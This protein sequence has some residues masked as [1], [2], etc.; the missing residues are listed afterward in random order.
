MMRS[1]GIIKYSLEYT[2]RLRLL[3][4]SLMKKIQNHDTSSHLYKPFYGVVENARAGRKLHNIVYKSFMAVVEFGDLKTVGLFIDLGIDL[5]KSEK[6]SEESSEGNSDESSEESWEEN[7]NLVLQRA[8]KNRCAEVMDFLLSTR[9]FDPSNTDEKTV[10]ALHV[11]AEVSNVRAVELLLE[12]GAEVDAV[13]YR[14]GFTSLEKAIEMVIILDGNSRRCEDEYAPCIELLLAYGAD[15]D[16]E[17]DG[18]NDTR[19]SED[20]VRFR[21]D[22]SK[23]YGAPLRVLLSHANLLMS[24]GRHLEKKTL[25]TD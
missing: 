14:N 23:I 11:A 12:A 2:S 18:G 19:I 20:W 15:I 3:L 6:N 5:K 24:L 25:S 17:P 4:E 1:T 16:G 9:I 8:A 22:Y 13:N 7:N 21:L 10:T